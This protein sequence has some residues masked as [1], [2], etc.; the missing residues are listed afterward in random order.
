MNAARGTRDVSG[1]DAILRQQIAGTLRS[2]FELYGYNPLETP[3]LERYETLTSKY[4]GGEEILKE[5]FKL[6][7]QGKRQLA[8]R[9]DLTV[10]LA[11]FL[12]CNPNL[13]MPFKRYAIGSVFRDGPLKP[14]RYREFTQCDV[15][16]VGNGSMAADAEI[17]RIALSVFEH[18]GFKVTVKVNNRKLLNGI[19]AAAGVEE[20]GME[21]AILSL[22]KLEKFGSEAVSREL[23]AKGLQ[24][25][26]IKKLMR[27]VMTEG[28]NQQKL[29]HLRKIIGNNRGLFEMGEVL[30]M[31]KN[32]SVNFDVSLARG[33]AYYT[34]TVF[35]VFLNKSRITSAVAGG[36]RYDGMIGKFV[37][38]NRDY[39]AVGISFGLDA[40]IDAVKMEEKGLKT[41]TRAYV[42][43]I[44]E[45]E[46]ASDVVDGLRAAGV[47]CDA[48]FSGKVGRSIEYAGACSIPFVIFVGK[49]ESKAGKVRI[50]NMETGKEKLL[51]VDGA[52]SLIRKFTGRSTIRV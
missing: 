4:A 31:A 51:G 37:D 2:V 36:G 3:V 46:K 40:I 8:L 38:N 49:R 30:R 48:D 44:G 16:V 12:A 25:S 20:A 32:R 5:I 21:T 47:N 13:K 26:V 34:G 45:P 29:T 18:M 43:S 19:L 1:Q 52:I 6:Q 15:D 17:I 42:I 35:E 10:P 11:R 14:G 24:S 9:Y 23:N 39:P 50:R 41:V 22:D 33:L 7:D 28:S 27:I